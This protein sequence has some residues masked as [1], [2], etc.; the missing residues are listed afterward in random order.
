M[1]TPAPSHRQNVGPGRAWPEIAK[2]HEGGAHAEECSGWWE[3]QALGPTQAEDRLS[4]HCPLCGLRLS[5]LSVAGRLKYNRPCPGI[6]YFMP[7]EMFSFY[8]K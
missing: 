6:I 4:L 1:E 8:F 5:L 7:R 3:S 2:V